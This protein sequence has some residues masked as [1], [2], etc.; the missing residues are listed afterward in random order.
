[1]R[2]APLALL[3]GSLFT[4]ACDDSDINL[5]LPVPVVGTFILQSVNGQRLPAVLVD[6]VSPPLRIEV[7]SGSITLNNNGTFTDL[8]EFRQTLGNMVTT[9]TLTCTGSYAVSGNVITF[10]EV[11]T[12]NGCGDRFTGI[13]TGNQLAASINGVPA[14]YVR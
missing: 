9:S 3:A 14:V 5:I 1:M 7:L 8:T 11:V 6:S 4:A 2:I 10:Q 13:Q 12:P